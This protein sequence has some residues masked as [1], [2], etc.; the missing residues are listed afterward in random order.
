MPRVRDGFVAAVYKSL[1]LI[2]SWHNTQGLTRI[3]R[4]I[5]IDVHLTHSLEGA[6]RKCS[7]LNIRTS[8]ALKILSCIPLEL[9]CTVL[10]HLSFFTF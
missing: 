3:Q 5:E 1:F 2:L 6:F 8:S 9:F 4:E 7:G 10:L